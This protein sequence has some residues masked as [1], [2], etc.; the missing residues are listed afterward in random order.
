MAKLGKV[1]DELVNGRS[2]MVILK[3]GLHLQFRVSEGICRLCCYR[4][5]ID[6]SDVEIAVVRRELQA[7][8]PDRIIQE[9]EPFTYTGGDKKVRHCRVLVWAEVVVQLG[10]GVTATAVAPAKYQ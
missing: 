4:I 8:L 2:Q 3:G 5:G 7:L 9:K 1:L 6:P 10:L